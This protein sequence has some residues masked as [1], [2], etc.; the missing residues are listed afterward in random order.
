MRDSLIDFLK[1]QFQQQ[2]ST[3]QNLAYYLGGLLGTSPEQLL[4]ADMPTL[5]ASAFIRPPQP[6][7]DVTY[8]AHDGSFSLL[9]WTP[10]MIQAQGG[11][12]QSQTVSSPQTS[13]KEEENLK[14]LTKR[15]DGRWQA[16]KVID[17]KRVYVYGKTQIEAR[18]K[19]RA[20]DTKRN[21]VRT[22]SFYDFAKYWL[23]TYKKGRVADKTYK[24]YANIIERHLN[25][26]TP[27][28]KVSLLQLQELLNGL[29]ASRIR[30]AVCQVM[31]AVIK[32]AYELDFIKKDISQFLDKGKIEKSRKR[33][34]LTLEE[35]RKLLAMLSDD[36][37]SRRVMFYICTG[38]RPAEIATVRKS[39]LRANWVKINGTKTTGSVR[40]V[41]ISERMS[42]MLAGESAEFFKFDAKRFRE[43][44]QRV[45]KNAGIERD[46]DTY[47]LRH[48]FATN[49]YIL[50]VPEK[51]RQTYMGHVDGSSMTNEVYTTFS[52]DVT[53]QDIYNIFGDW[54]PK[55]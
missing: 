14:Y 34:A 15:S 25:I 42:A 32:K 19:L 46:V 50:R 13:K 17:G 8:T 47:T 21:R 33:R 49:L 2:K 23:E 24:D 7:D 45:C 36:I 55:F 1:A 9:K 11:D 10:D 43:H 5:D 18:N 48:T 27:I 31:K 54:L 44:L 6:R 41:K 22:Y 3:L 12:I 35:Q 51:D 20:L 30:E 37:F 29:S 38:A 16:S 39:E 28:N 52:P 40:W 53:A 4:L 26:K